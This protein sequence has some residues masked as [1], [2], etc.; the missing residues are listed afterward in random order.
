M[1]IQTIKLDY[2]Q[3]Y[4]HC[5]VANTIVIRTIFTLFIPNNKQNK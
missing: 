3:M 1:T 4:L 5:M 2:K